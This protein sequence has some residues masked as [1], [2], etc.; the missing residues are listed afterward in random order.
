LFEPLIYEQLQEA[1]LELSHNHI[2][3]LTSDVEAIK[4]ALQAISFKKRPKLAVETS[5]QLHKRARINETAPLGNTP[6]WP[7][8]QRQNTAE[9]VYADSDEEHSDGGPLEVIVEP[10]PVTDSSHR[11]PT[12]TKG[13]SHEQL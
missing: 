5:G 1:S 8:S 7:D 2:V 11:Y 9:L 12:C 10:W 3:A 13:A 4:S 6:P